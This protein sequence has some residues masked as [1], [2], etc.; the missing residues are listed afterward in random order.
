VDE[1]LG[2]KTIHFVTPPASPNA[3]DPLNHHCPRPAALMDRLG[4][5]LQR[6]LKIPAP[7]VPGGEGGTAL[8]DLPWD[9]DLE[10]MKRRHRQQFAARAR[11]TH[12]REVHALDRLKRQHRREFTH[13]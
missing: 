1:I 12:D 2:D 8:A 13:R 11:E 5:F 4:A 10:A 3:N 6:V 9:A 7:P